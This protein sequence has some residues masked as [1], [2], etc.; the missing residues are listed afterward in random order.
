MHPLSHDLCHL[1]TITCIT[2]LKNVLSIFSVLFVFVFMVTVTLMLT[3][4]L[5]LYCVICLILLDAWPLVVRFRMAWVW[6][7]N[8]KMGWVSVPSDSRYFFLRVFVRV[9]PPTFSYWQGLNSRHCI[10]EAPKRNW[11]IIIYVIEYRCT[12]LSLF[13]AACQASYLG[14][15]T[16]PGYPVSIYLND[17]D[18]EMSCL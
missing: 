15:L 11:L 18:W 2:P 7:S 4:T 6:V 1:V 16:R 10:L 5:N 3:L 8:F 9:S 12:K 14:L 13:A 17:C